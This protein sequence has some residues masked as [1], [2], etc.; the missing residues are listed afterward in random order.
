MGLGP[1][2]GTQGRRPTRWNSGVGDERKVFTY[3][4]LRP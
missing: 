3:E 2:T 4:L 1:E